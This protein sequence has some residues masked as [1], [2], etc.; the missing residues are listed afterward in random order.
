M[1]LVALDLNATRVRAVRG[2][3]GDYP[4]AVPLDPPRPE[5]VLALNLSGRTPVVGEAALRAARQTP[6]LT[7]QNFLPRLGEAPPPGRNWVHTRHKLDP[8]GAL[9]LVLQQVARACRESG[10]VVLAVPSYLSV[11]QVETV[12]T[13]ADKAGLPLFGSVATPL[14]AALAAHAEQAWYHSTI[15]VDV[16]EQAL[17]LATVGST[18][19]QAQLLDVRCWPQLGLRVWRERLLN[20][21]AD[22][23][24][25]DS[26][27]DPRESPAAE[28]SLFD[29]LDDVL[30]AAQHGRMTKLTV[31]SAQRFQNLV[32]QAHDPATFC[33]A[34]VRQTLGEVEALFRAP[35]PDGPPGTILVTAAAA[36]LPGLVAGLHV[37]VPS[38]MPVPMSKPRPA[39]SALEDFG[40]NLLEDSG[41][42]PRSVVVLTADAPARGAHAV[43]AYFQRGDM[44]CGHL[45]EAAPLPLPQ[46]LEAGPARLHFQGQDF[47][48]GAG[49]FTIGR[50]PGV[51]LLFD[52]ERWPG[53]AGRHCEIVYD[54][55]AHILCDHSRQGTLVNDQPATQAVPLRPGDWIRLGPDGPLLRFLGQTA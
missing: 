54:H 26:R 17:T 55:R 31:R 40:S 19:G 15:V 46:P 28:Q 35:W 22:C 11:A 24:I 34:L 42:E 20:A 12:L 6:H 47:L 16:D 48:L 30:D 14:A 49:S 41:E 21:V 25:L 8:V 45:G 7:W 32:L 51:D 23:C 2:Y 37:C 3:V 36:R 50:M 13:L 29:Q 1:S 44:V 39:P 27:W 52:G 33:A 4:G 38:W 5:L 9:G 10:G 53:V 43:G 18:Q